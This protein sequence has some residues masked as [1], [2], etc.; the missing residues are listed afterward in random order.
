MRQKP[1]PPIAF[2]LRV[3]D[4]CAFLGIGRSKLY[5]L[6]HQGKLHAYRPAGRTTFSAPTWRPSPR[7]NLIPG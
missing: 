6:V 1:I 7:G 4:A 5:Q 2:A 3:N